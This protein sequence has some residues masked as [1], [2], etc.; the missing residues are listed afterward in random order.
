[1]NFMRLGRPRLELV[2]IAV[3]GSWHILGAGLDHRET[4]RHTK[5]FISFFEHA[6]TVCNLASGRMLCNIHHNLSCAI[7]RDPSE[8]LPVRLKNAPTNLRK[9]RHIHK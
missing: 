9:L 1:M 5:I 8:E 6:S 2:K 4:Q 3:D 7:I